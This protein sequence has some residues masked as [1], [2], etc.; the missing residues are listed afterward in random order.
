[1]FPILIVDPP[2]Q[3]GKA[4]AYQGHKME[5]GPLMNCP[6]SLVIKVLKGHPGNKTHSTLF[7]ATV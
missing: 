1:M 2:S 3:P 6:G 4:C 5:R 7:W